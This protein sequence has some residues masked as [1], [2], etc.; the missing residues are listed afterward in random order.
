MVQ[1]TTINK[2]QKSVFTVRL[3]L[4]SVHV[5]QYQPDNLTTPLPHL[6]KNLLRRR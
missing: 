2:V 4:S 5:R 3:V 1:G 6:Y